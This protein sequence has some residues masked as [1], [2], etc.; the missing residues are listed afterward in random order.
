MGA[1]HFTGRKASLEAQIQGPRAKTEAAPDS[2]S[3]SPAHLASSPQNEAELRKRVPGE[4]DCVPPMSD[5]S[6]GDERAGRDSVPLYQGAPWAVCPFEPQ[7]RS[8]QQKGGLARQKQGEPS[9]EQPRGNVTGLVGRESLRER[10]RKPRRD[11][12]QGKP[13]AAG[14]LGYGDSKE[15][16]A[17]GGAA[18]V[19]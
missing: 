7:G 16:E 2:V 12:A 1:L 5:S 15:T 9:A 4:S 17:L 11:W 10:A 19:R 14:G 18:L 8:F 6:Q 3:L 13:R